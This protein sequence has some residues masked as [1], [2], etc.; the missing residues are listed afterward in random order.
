MLTHSA[1]ASNFTMA[2]QYMHLECKDI[3]SPR[4]EVNGGEMIA[5]SGAS[6]AQIARTGFR[7]ICTFKY[8]SA[9]S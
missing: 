7:H 8:R 4:T 2:T 6:V 9:T 5:T 1:P 3:L